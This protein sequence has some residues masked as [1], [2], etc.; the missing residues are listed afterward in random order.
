MKYICLI[1]R[2]IIWLVKNIFY[3]I[4]CIFP[5]DKNLVIFES[6]LGQSFSGSPKYIYLKLKEENKKN[7]VKC[8]FTFNS[9]EKFKDIIIDKN[10]ILVK[11]KSFRHYYYLARAKFWVRNSES[12]VIMKKRKSTIYIQTWHGTPLKKMFYDDLNFMNQNAIFMYKFKNAIKSWDYFISPNEYTEKIFNNF[13]E[14]DIINLQLG[15]P[16]ND[17]LVN[18]SNLDKENIKFRLGIPKDK[19]VILYAPT[20]RDYEYNEGMTNFQFKLDFKMIN[21]KLKDYIIIV[22]AHYYVSE[23]AK[24]D[25]FNNVYNFSNPNYDIQELYII[26]DILITDYSSVMFDY[27]YTK[28]PILFYVYDYEKYQSSRGNYFSLK[29][30]APGPLLYSTEEIIESIKNINTLQVQY[31]NKYDKFYNNFCSYSIGESSK[32]IVDIIMENI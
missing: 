31:K 15:Y 21:E 9:P 8:V 20:F 6:Y 7:N 11:N 18:S 10:T 16:R 22:R 1:F 14:H 12:I 27:A 29:S 25:S 23:L 3:S 13:F 2:N 24:L 30:N 17:I 4:L 19:K 26:S 32:S 28:K 5:V